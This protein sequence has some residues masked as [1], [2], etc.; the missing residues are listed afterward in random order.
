MFADDTTLFSTGKNV[1]E[2]ASDVLSWARQNRMALNVTKTK[3][4]L[5]TS[6]QKRGLRSSKTLDV[7]INDSPIQ[8]VRCVKVLGVTFDESASW[9]PMYNLFVNNLT[10]TSLLRR[11]SPY[12]NKSGTLRLYNV[13]LQSKLLYCSSVWGSCSRTLLLQLLCLQKHA[14][15]I[16]LSPH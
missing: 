16:I 3:C 15:R 12:L 9:D 1:P 4:M 14:A 2:I 10:V 7:S 13:C 8:Q 11:I 6:Q 5:V